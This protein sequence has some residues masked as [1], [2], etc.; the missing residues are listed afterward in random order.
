MSPKIASHQNV[1]IKKWLIRKEECTVNNMQRNGVVFQTFGFLPFFRGEGG[2]YYWH[3]TTAFVKGQFLPCQRSQVAWVLAS[4]FT[5]SDHWFRGYRCRDLDQ[6]GLQTDS[7]LCS[8]A[9]VSHCLQSR[10]ESSWTG[11]LF[12][13]ISASFVSLSSSFIFQSSLSCAQS[14]FL[15]WTSAFH[16]LLLDI[17]FWVLHTKSFLSWSS[18]D[19]RSSP[20]NHAQA[21]PPTLLHLVLQ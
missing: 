7:I 17:C 16:S 2:R 6:S 21:P 9:S 12:C 5:G 15:R 11:S 3:P 13:C 8:R 1:N 10:S 14:C 20:V 18:E 4:S 19:R